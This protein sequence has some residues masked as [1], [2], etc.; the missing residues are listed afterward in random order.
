MNRDRFTVPMHRY[1]QIAVVT[2]VGIAVLVVAGGIV[3][4]TGSGLGCDDWPGCNNTSFVDVSSSHTA[5]EQINRLL[6]GVI[7]VPTLALVVCAPYVAPRRRGL[8]GPAA[9]VLATVLANAVL[10]GI[11]V[12]GELHPALVQSHFI[13]AMVSIT[14]ALIAVHRSGPDEVARVV[15]PRPVA[16]M[17]WGFGALTAVALVT[18]TVVTG[19][20]P[21]AG[22]ERAQRFGFDISTVA[23]LHA[24]TVWLAV[25][26]CLV[27]LAVLRRH[28]ML[29]GHRSRV[30][31][32]VF[33]ALVQ[34]GIG[35][36]Q[37]ANGVPELLVGAHLAGATAVWA[38]TVHVV[39]NGIEPG[40][41]GRASLPPGGGELLVGPTS[42]RV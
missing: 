41:I 19:T 36:V 21:H 14:F 1:H 42:G 32:W 35:Y 11:A 40:S 3:R 2:A 30:S 26:S 37:Y 18:G 10:G 7:G 6:S 31:T 39:A 24:T 22:D 17:L 27:L 23:R 33:V 28:G 13:L 4:L 8:I 38:A 25:A 9:G 5:I 29:D 34:G 12:R 15:L 20:G 16:G